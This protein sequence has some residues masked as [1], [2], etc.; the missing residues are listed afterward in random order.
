VTARGPSRSHYPGRLAAAEVLPFAAA[1]GPAGL[2]SNDDSAE[3]GG[4]VFK[5]SITLVITTE[6]SGA[7]AG[8]GDGHGEGEGEEGELAKHGGPLGGE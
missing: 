5:G 6:A 7:G 8:G 1:R 2:G 4:R 3:T